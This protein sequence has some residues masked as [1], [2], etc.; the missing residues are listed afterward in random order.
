MLSNGVT[1]KGSPSSSTKYRH[2][3]LWPILTKKA[4]VS[5]SSRWL[6]RFQVPRTRNIG[7]KR[8]SLE[9]RLVPCSLCRYSTA[10]VRSRMYPQNDVSAWSAEAFLVG[11]KAVCLTSDRPLFF[12]SFF[13]RNKKGPLCSGGL[14]NLNVD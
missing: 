1:L 13:A 10:L 7:Y 3:L 11:R 6:S 8:L 4:S 2:L 12:S 5:L 9:G 14:D